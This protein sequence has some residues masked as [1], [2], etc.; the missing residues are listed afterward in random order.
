[1]FHVWTWRPAQPTHLGEPDAQNNNDTP[2]STMRLTHTL[3]SDIPD[4]DC[5]SSDLDDQDQQQLRQQLQY[6]EDFLIYN[7]MA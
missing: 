7:E 2:V 4:G 6:E 3:S 1:M 5:S